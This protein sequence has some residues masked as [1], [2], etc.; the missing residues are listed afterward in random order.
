[1]INTLPDCYRI[2]DDGQVPFG[3]K[4]LLVEGVDDVFVIHYLCQAIGLERDFQI[5]SL[6]GKA[7]L[8]NALTII[9]IE[10]Q[11]IRLGVVLDAD[12]NFQQSINNIEQSVEIAGINQS[13][14]LFHFPNN[15]DKGTLEHLVILSF[16]NT[17]LWECA[18]DFYQCVTA[19]N[20]LTF[21]DNEKAKLL[22]KAFLL[23]K[24]DKASITHAAKQGW[25]DFNHTC[26]QELKTY[27]QNF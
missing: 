11:V 4:V 19:E 14:Q 23:H 25:L 2:N 7:N 8:V 22:V 9:S 20:S 6:G 15:Q 3:A 17:T 12:D 1:M 10:T 21:S 16:I 18:T 5:W 26:F 27:L 24:K 13:L